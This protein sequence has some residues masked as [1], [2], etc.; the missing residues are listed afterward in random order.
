M[1]AL[2]Q[3]QLGEKST[4][5]HI[6]T[7]AGQPEYVPNSKGFKEFFSEHQLN[8]ANMSFEVYYA[9]DKP[10]HIYDYSPEEIAEKIWERITDVPS[11]AGIEYYSER[12]KKMRTFYSKSDVLK[13]IINKNISETEPFPRILEQEVYQ[14]DGSFG[15]NQYTYSWYSNG[16]FWALAS[17]NTTTLKYGPLPVAKPENVLNI[18]GVFEAEDEFLLYLYTQINSQASLPSFLKDRILISFTNRTDA[19]K[20]WFVQGL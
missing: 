18:I 7:K 12:R 3:T 4:F 14:E 19:L 13:T 10:L 17:L 5:L 9:L 1:P 8:E 16:H 20:S 6:N 2:V 11:L 15:K